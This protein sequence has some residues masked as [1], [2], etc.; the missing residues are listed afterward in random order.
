MLSRYPVLGLLSLLA[1]TL[2]SSSYAQSEVGQVPTEP[3]VCDAHNVTTRVVSVRKVGPGEIAIEVEYE[4]TANFPVKLN[5]AGGVSIFDS[6]GDKW[7]GD[8]NGLNRKGDIP[9]GIKFKHRYRFTKI[10]GGADATSVSFVHHFR[11][12]GKKGLQGTCKFDA[13]NLPLAGS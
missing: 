8:G 5:A 9:P 4:N 12:W 2:C 10:S 13:K 6:N 1:S 3:V 11:V 7:D